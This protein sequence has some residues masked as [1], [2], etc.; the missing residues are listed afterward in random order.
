MDCLTFVIIGRPYAH[1]KKR[2]HRGGMFMSVCPLCNGL[3]SFRLKCPFC[4]RTL[5]DTGKLENYFEP[6]SPY[7]DEEILDQT[8]GVG[9]NQCIHLF[10]CPRCHYDKRYTV[11]QIDI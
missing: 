7:L 8:D 6:Y 5:E 3:T 4:G 10:H 9:E 2:H 1:A 11:G